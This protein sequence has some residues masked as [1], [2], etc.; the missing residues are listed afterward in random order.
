MEGGAPPNPDMARPM[1][2]AGPSGNGSL[3]ETAPSNDFP[4]FEDSDGSS[5]R[6]WG[7]RFGILF[8]FRRWR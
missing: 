1:S 8:L 2:W 7:N 5:F 6:G 3:S 4:W